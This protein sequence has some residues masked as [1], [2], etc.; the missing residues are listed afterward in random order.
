M[1]KVKITNE[2]GQ[3]VNGY[4][5]DQYTAD[6]KKKEKLKER[7][8]IAYLLVAITAFS[9]AIVSQIRKKHGSS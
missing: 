4:I 6:Q 9:I 7:L 3:V 1:T 8:H 5:D 2:S